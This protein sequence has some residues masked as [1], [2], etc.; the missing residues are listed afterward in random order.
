MTT[1][2]NLSNPIEVTDIVSYNNG[3]ITFKPKQVEEI[4]AVEF[5]E[6]LRKEYYTYGGKVE[7]WHD[8]KNTY[9]SKQLYEIFKNQK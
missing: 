8:N 2:M 5:A 9:T 1:V 4:E 6:W 3:V 7:K